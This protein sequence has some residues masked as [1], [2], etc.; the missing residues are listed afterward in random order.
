MT[1]LT[2]FLPGGHPLAQS[3]TPREGRP[4]TLLHATSCWVPRKGAPWTDLGTTTLHP[5]TPTDQN[6]HQGTL[7]SWF[8]VSVASSWCPC[9]SK[10]QFSTCR[11]GPGKLKGAGKVRTESS[12][13][14][15]PV[16]SVWGYTGSAQGLLT[17]NGLVLGDHSSRC[18]RPQRQG[19]GSESLASCL[20][21]FHAQLA[22]S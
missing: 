16:S 7:V 19:K 4:R 20:Q 1:L 17:H 14:G 9:T 12:E 22:G 5:G 3:Q 21:S 2:G 13:A 11:V 8:A 15:L 6:F 18:S 10:T